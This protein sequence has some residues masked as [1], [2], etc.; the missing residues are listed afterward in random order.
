[1]IEKKEELKRQVSGLQ[2]C[3]EETGRMKRS[4]KGGKAKEKSREQNSEIRQH[5]EQSEYKEDFF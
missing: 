3:K 1:M 5:S 4:V 2:I